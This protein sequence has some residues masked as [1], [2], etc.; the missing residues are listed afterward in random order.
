MPETYRIPVVL[1]TKG[2]AEAARQSKELSGSLGGLSTSSK[3]VGAALKNMSQIALGGLGIEKLAHTVGTFNKG[4]YDLSRQGK[5]AGISFKQISDGVEQL[6]SKTMLSRQE[7]ANF[8]KQVNQMTVGAKM[9]A[10]EISR[11]GQVIYREF[12]SSVEDATESLQKLMQVQNKNTEVFK[13]MQDGMDPS[14]AGALGLAMESLYGISSDASDAAIRFT[15]NIAK[16][17]K[18]LDANEKQLR[19]M[20]DALKEADKTAADT[21]LDYGLKSQES[22]KKTYEV[23][24]SVQK[25]LQE[26]PA[27]I[28][29]AGVAFGA[30]SAVPTLFGN[31]LSAGKSLKG[32]WGG[33][34]GG[35]GG[36]GFLS[37]IGGMI[38]GLFSKKGSG[39]GAKGGGKGGL[40]AGAASMVGSLLGSGGGGAGAKETM[41]GDMCGKCTDA[42]REGAQQGTADGNEKLPAALSNVVERGL[43]RI[44]EKLGLKVSEGFSKRMLTTVFGKGLV[45]TG[46][47]LLATSAG[48]MG[49]A[50]LGGAVG[51]GAGAI[52][53]LIGGAVG[54]AIEASGS[55]KA[56]AGVRAGSGI[57]GMAMSG[58]SIGG[59]VGAG[60]GG[61]G[62]APGAILGGIAGAAYG[63]ISSFDDI[64]AATGEWAS[65]LWHS[66][67]EVAKAQKSI[68][69]EYGLAEV[70]LPGWW[71]TTTNFFAGF[72]GAGET[73]TEM[74]TR[75]NM[76]GTAKAATDADAA[77]GKGPKW[78]EMS[79]K[80]QAEKTKITAEKTKEL[81]KL[82]AVGANS[83]DTM[84]QL[85]AATMQNIMQEALGDTGRRSGP[86]EAIKALQ[87]YQAGKL[88]KDLALALASVLGN[89]GRSGAAKEK[90]ISQYGSHLGADSS[91]IEAL[92]T[93]ELITKSDEVRV[94]VLRQ[95]VVYTEQQN[96]LISDRSGYLSA[97]SNFYANIIGQEDTALKLAR[98]SLES[99]K[100]AAA[101]AKKAMDD[102][103]GNYDKNIA[104]VQE[105]IATWKSSGKVIQEYNGQQK[106]TADL[107]SDHEAVILGLQAQKAK[108]GKD[109]VEL[110][111][112]SV[113]KGIQ[114]TK[115]Y[116]PQIDLLRE[117]NSVLE[118]QQE[119]NKSLYA[120]AGAQIGI[121]Q[122]Q[123]K[124]RSNEIE[125]LEKKLKAALAVEKTD[126]NYIA[127]QRNA[128]Q[129][130]KEI[131]VAKRAQ[132]EM[133]KEISEGYLDAMMASSNAEGTFSKFIMGREAGIGL[134]Q[135]TMGAEQ[136]QKMGMIGGGAE[137][138]MM[139]VEAG[140][141]IT[142]DQGKMEE[143]TGQYMAKRPQGQRPFMGNSSAW[144]A[145]YPGMEGAGLSAAN[146]ANMDAGF[147]PG[148][149]NE[150]P[151]AKEAR[152]MAKEAM[153]KVAPLQAKQREGFNTPTLNSEVEKA[154]QKSG[155]LMGEANAIQQIDDMATAVE[156]GMI[157]AIG[158]TGMAT[159]GGGAAAGTPG[160]TTA[161][162]QQIVDGHLVTLINLV[163]KP[164]PAEPDDVGVTPTKVPEGDSFWKSIKESFKNAMAAPTNV[165]QKI[166]SEA[167]EQE[168]FIDRYQNEEIRK[169]P[170]LAGQL[171]RIKH[172]MLG[173]TMGIRM[174]LGDITGGGAIQENPRSSI[175]PVN[176][177]SIAEEMNYQRDSAEKTQ[178]NTGDTVD[179]TRRTADATERLANAAAG[180]AQQY[181]PGAQPGGGAGGFGFDYF[182]KMMDAQTGM[183]SSVFEKGVGFSSGGMVYGATGGDKV[184]AVLEHGEM[185]LSKSDVANNPSVRHFQDGGKAGEPGG[186][187]QTPNPTETLAEQSMREMKERQTQADKQR[188]EKKTAKM[189]SKIME[190]MGGVAGPEELAK[191][192]G[193]SSPE[194]LSKMMGGMSPDE[195]F[196]IAGK[197]VVPEALSK[198]MGAPT[199]EFISKM[200]EGM[201]GAAGPKE[202]AKMMGAP[203]PEF[204]SKMM[205][206]GGK[207]VI[208]EALS[209]MMGASGPEIVDAMAKSGG[210][211]GIAGSLFE[212]KSFVST[213]RSNEPMLKTYNL[214]GKPKAPKPVVEEEKV[215]IQEGRAM[216]EFP[217]EM[218]AVKAPPTATPPKPSTEPFTGAD[219]AAAVHKAKVDQWNQSVEDQRKWAQ[220]SSDIEIAYED[221]NK[222][223]TKKNKD[224]DAKIDE[225]EKSLAAKL[226][227]SQEATVSL[228]EKNSRFED[229]KK[230][231]LAL[232]NKEGRNP[233]DEAKL[234][235]LGESLLK[236]GD[237]KKG[238]GDEYNPAHRSSPLK[239][240]FQDEYRKTVK[241]EPSEEYIN[242]KLK[243]HEEERIK[244]IQNKQNAI[245]ATSKAEEA[246][247]NKQR[248]RMERWLEDNPPPPS[249]AVVEPSG[250]KTELLSPQQA[251]EKKYQDETTRARKMAEDK[252]SI[253]GER[254]AGLG[255]EASASPSKMDKLNKEKEDFVSMSAKT[256]HMSEDDAKSQLESHEETRKKRDEYEQLLNKEKPRGGGTRGADEKD[257]KRL[258]Q[259]KNELKNE[260]GEWKKSDLEDSIE[261]S[262][263]NSKEA[264]AKAYEMS[265][266]FGNKG[267]AI[268]EALKQ[269]KE[270]EDAEYK[271]AEKYM[272]YWQDKNL[273][274]SDQAEKEWADKN[275]P[276]EAK[277][278]DMAAVKKKDQEEND[279]EE[280]RVA[281]EARAKAA[282]GGTAKEVLERALNRDVAKDKQQ[283]A[284]D[285]ANKHASEARETA[286]A[287]GAAGDK[288]ASGEKGQNEAE[289]SKPKTNAG[290]MQ[291]FQDR[292]KQEYIKKYGSVEAGQK[293]QNAEAI[294][295]AKELRESRRRGPGAA[296]GPAAGR[297]PGAVPAAGKAPGAETQE[298]ESIRNRARALGLSGTGKLFNI[299]Q[300]I[301]Q[302]EAAR[303][304]RPSGTKPDLKTARDDS[305]DSIRARVA[306]QQADS[307]LI[308][309]RQ[310][311]V[312]GPVTLHQVTRE[313]TDAEKERR[314]KQEG[315]SEQPKRPAAK[316]TEQATYEAGVE[317]EKRQKVA[318]EGMRGKDKEGKEWSIKTG[319][320]L[321]SADSKKSRSGENK[322]GK[323][324][325]IKTDKELADADA[326]RRG[327]YAPGSG[328]VAPGEMSETTSD[329]LARNQAE[330]NKSNLESAA[331]QSA[332]S[333]MGTANDW[334]AQAEIA[335]SKG[336][337]EG[338]KQFDDMMSR[339][340]AGKSEREW[341]QIKRD[342]KWNEEQRVAALEE[343]S[344][345]ALSRP[346]PEQGRVSEPSSPEDETN[347]VA[348]LADEKRRN[349]EARFAEE[350]KRNSEANLSKDRQKYKEKVA[351]KPE[352]YFAMGGPVWNPPGYAV[353]GEVDSVPAMLAPGEFVV[354]SREAQKPENMS[355]LQHMNAGGDIAQRLS[356]GGMVLNNVFSPV[357][358][359]PM[360]GSRH[361]ADGGVV[362]SF[363]NTFNVGG[364]NYK[365]MMKEIG[366][367]L[368][369]Q[370]EYPYGGTGRRAVI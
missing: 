68:T 298:E 301:R 369:S 67:D 44:G 3:N 355:V 209:K 59:A 349:E 195:I 78:D 16:Q 296:A 277:P 219:Y 224:A 9:S 127:N 18:G 299:K 175:G 136:G 51:G 281:S 357:I 168:G 245:N 283:E 172:P 160:E 96:K 13:A 133:T 186:T 162:K 324:W 151:A 216:L 2:F 184:P 84:G 210:M 345:Q 285:E 287:S 104:K 302:I 53:S 91:Q 75:L 297:A 65:K 139:R 206:M 207:G 66:G 258:E 218:Q 214:E 323:K 76:S 343:Q 74:L 43:P 19:G 198:M 278:Q 177:D 232:K 271:H 103:G 102:Q 1:E 187:T 240:A 331:N 322:E 36:K 361:M 247:R 154:K 259:L 134:L 180:P 269:H 144:G 114:L 8:F 60:F 205:E 95:Q 280:K 215:N 234:K 318:A 61:I 295:K 276:V 356:A 273:K 79:S 231:F 35:G 315:F 57:L 152:Q 111:K 42:I 196:K 87:D 265:V 252:L 254:A 156:K 163:K 350:M 63:V 327:K 262:G 225:H 320:G 72:V 169:D 217:A 362:S 308:K 132:A 15:T 77:A 173:Q 32:M 242:R 249:K 110:Q 52:V 108:L 46:G 321:E 6:A 199:P 363:S 161:G 41:Q 138:P 326:V 141:G 312:S 279:A 164:T 211:R 300:Q 328:G 191:A 353:G 92:R 121:M 135:R 128:L 165:E 174:D 338:A 116:D 123:Y 193:L 303:A 264:K 370:M 332:L 109:Y 337:E 124:V 197:G 122:Q 244:L 333:T 293:A 182:E 71:D 20:S 14:V 313:E 309:D 335:K 112:E 239:T 237:F 248:G 329:F 282:K 115:V 221:K 49:R 243:T 82:S 294:A 189:I 226:G 235:S 119:L 99:S 125:L 142:A 10:N 263:K 304:A 307:A 5:L 159:P 137:A 183:F 201:G 166:S 270:R 364:G 149:V 167:S 347:E 80:Q 351:G 334:K 268:S 339:Q 88:P 286:G 314:W 153:S 7:S 230:E 30:L 98:E 146:A 17:G 292:V 236:T 366:G 81:F 107:I 54:D 113:E 255:Q 64:K 22:L 342:K 241:A 145:T 48:T 344:K 290:N 192:M 56:G 202:L 330:I 148:R 288:G 256:L 185:V 129:I 158:K 208:P 155:Q 223:L 267:Y 40:L 94:Q 306:E 70:K 150:T 120:G 93:S 24:T 178:E 39:G 305:F 131:N 228:M 200:M 220:T 340:I 130:V 238:E 317:E 50:A 272:V 55:K 260:K 348:R 367:Y 47:K 246:I 341:A 157:A 250:Q 253:P 204:L 229:E 143:V 21:K 12:G 23:M 86:D 289:E 261:T 190:S 346:M 97:Q 171:N 90:A 316:T 126:K 100:A 352:Q 188:A 101:N 4:M 311:N 83:G 360:G 62:A 34:G 89:K 319:A 85:N 147:A 176:F 222:G 194:E 105:L 213:P 227:I 274:P 368:S 140:V 275:K 179:A 28:I 310:K 117:Q 31:I 359:S 336:Q 26:M 45:Q 73:A 291:E 106:A 358:P 181:Q 365:E 69:D 29:Q 284:A 266:A 212:E 203:T 233:N 25:L 33:G 37:N 251:W 38:S 354:R 11:L 118:S 58:A 170:A 325:S 27:T 257:V